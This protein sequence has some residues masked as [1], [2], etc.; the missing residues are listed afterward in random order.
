MTQITTQ[1][2]RFHSEIS[3]NV[4][5]LERAR[6]RINTEINSYLR[7]DD[8]ESVRLFTNIYALLY[9]SWTETYL[10][11]LVHTPNGFTPSEKTHVLNNR[12]IIIKWEKCIDTAFNKLIH[13]DPTIPNQSEK[14]HKLVDDYL[15]TQAKIRNKIAHG[16]WANPLFS[17]NLS[18]D[19]DMKILMGLVDVIQ[20]DLW[21]EIVKQLALIV[22]GVIDAKVHNNFIAHYNHYINRLTSIQ[23]IITERS[24]WTLEDKQ[25][26]L[27]LKAFKTN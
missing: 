9:F 20:I 13:H 6:K 4:R 14:I 7:K 18:L 10:V 23:N 21:F 17:N 11:K 24:K 16:Q 3:E 19:P 12:D 15:N 26:R 25:N 27:K 5:L 22:N 2:Q 8:M 1:D